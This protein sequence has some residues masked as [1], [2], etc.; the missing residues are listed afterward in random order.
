MT[1]RK[2]PQWN[3]RP[4]AP[5]IEATEKLKKAGGWTHDRTAEICVAALFG[6]DDPEIAGQLEKARRLISEKGIQLR[7]NLP[8]C[9]PSLAFSA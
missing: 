8:S 6:T 2:S 7:F 1:K 5:F 9:Q 3:T 4:R